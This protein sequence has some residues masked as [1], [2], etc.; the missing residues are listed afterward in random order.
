MCNFFYDMHI[1]ESIACE[2]YSETMS[3]WVIFI[4][5]AYRFHAYDVEK[6]K[7]G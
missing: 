7:N 6:Y 5:Q 2:N 3:F 4:Y 1:A